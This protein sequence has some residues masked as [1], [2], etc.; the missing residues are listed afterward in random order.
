MDAEK[1][2][3]SFGFTTFVPFFKET[4]RVFDKQVKI[5]SLNKKTP[6]PL[7]PTI[8]N[9]LFLRASHKT[10]VTILNRAESHMEEIEKLLGTFGLGRA[11]V[12][13]NWRYMKILL[14]R[15]LK[16]AFLHCDM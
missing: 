16:R 5:L 11:V 12:F 8:T 15:L 14:K 7:P 2:L 6:P 13:I 1:R 4:W 10:A 9:E 3:K